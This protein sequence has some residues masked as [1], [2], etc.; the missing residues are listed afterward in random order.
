MASFNNA[1]PT[2]ACVRIPRG[3]GGTRK[4]SLVRR[5]SHFLY[6]LSLSSF[7]AL[8]HTYRP[9]YTTW[10]HGAWAQRIQKRKRTGVKTVIHLHLMQTLRTR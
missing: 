9:T 10:W 4:R 2:V 6:R 7:K 3:G 8:S 1:A 5:G